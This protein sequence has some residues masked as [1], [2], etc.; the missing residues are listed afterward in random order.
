MRKMIQFWKNANDMTREKTISYDIISKWYFS[1]I[2]SQRRKKLKTRHVFF[3]TFKQPRAAPLVLLCLA[4]WDE[5]SI[6][7]ILQMILRLCTC[8]RLKWHKSDFFALMW[9][10]SDSSELCECK[11]SIFSNQIWASFICV[12]FFP[13]AFF[14]YY[15]HHPVFTVWQQW[16]IFS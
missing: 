6:E 10:K 8:I 15:Y 16:L 7:T 13:L 5:V 2:N 1:G 3:F 9:H 12:V 14:A 11:H 4:L